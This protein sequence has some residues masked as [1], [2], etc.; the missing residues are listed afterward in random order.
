MIKNQRK[1]QEKTNTW[2]NLKDAKENLY[3]S[4]SL[5]L[6]ELFLKIN[7]AMTRKV[8]IKALNLISK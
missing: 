8:P 1:K 7:A 6:S 4:V 3:N 5:L 2:T